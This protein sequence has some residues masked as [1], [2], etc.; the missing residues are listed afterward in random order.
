MVLLL[1][2]DGLYCGDLQ[3]AARQQPAAGAPSIRA[4]SSSRLAA[5]ADG[6]RLLTAR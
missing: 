2:V 3:Q 4:G 5:T 1:F 6:A